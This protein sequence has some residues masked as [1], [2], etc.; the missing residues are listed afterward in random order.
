MRRADEISGL[1]P[2]LPSKR[3]ANLSFSAPL[4]VEIVFLLPPCHLA[5]PDVVVI[6]CSVVP[7]RVA[8]F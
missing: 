8:L 7:F 6:R 2:G 5:D 4:R 3:L 1:E